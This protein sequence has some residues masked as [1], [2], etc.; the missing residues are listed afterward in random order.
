M[1]GCIA[2]AS[3]RDA[4]GLKL[5]GSAVTKSNAVVVWE[6]WDWKESKG[7][8]PEENTGNQQGL[9][10]CESVVSAVFDLGLVFSDHRGVD[11]R[12]S[13]SDLWHW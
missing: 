5:T 11:L 13:A 7:R 3:L 2:G 4:P 9:H 6:Q 8:R 10:M 12:L 1:L